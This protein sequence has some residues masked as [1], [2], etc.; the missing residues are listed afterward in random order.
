MCLAVYSIIGSMGARV[1]SQY[2]NDESKF[3]TIE[4]PTKQSKYRGNII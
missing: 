3:A 4:H 2:T 1:I